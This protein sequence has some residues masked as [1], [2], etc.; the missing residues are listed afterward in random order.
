LQNGS[1]LFMVCSAIDSVLDALR[2]IFEQGTSPKCFHVLAEGGTRRWREID[3]SDIYFDY[4]RQSAR[5]S[6]LKDP[7]IVEIR[8]PGNPARRPA[9]LSNH[10]AAP[11]SAS[12]DREL[13]RSE[14]TPWL[15]VVR[16][17]RGHSLVLRGFTRAKMTRW[18]RSRIR[19]LL[20][21]S[22]LI[23]TALRAGIS[24]HREATA[25]AEDDEA[26]ERRDEDDGTRTRE[27]RKLSRVYGIY[28]QQL[29]TI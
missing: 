29:R 11:G 2:G 19:S 23:S 26:E 3:R 15:F 12:R 9:Y 24:D 13:P 5:S 6:R 20:S 27:P 10:E 25:G 17:L 18:K 28:V 8:P 7:G 14:I 22:H 16:V 21:T 1:W 4:L